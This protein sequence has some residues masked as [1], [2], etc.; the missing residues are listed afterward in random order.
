MLGWAGEA[1]AQPDDIIIE[2]VGPKEVREDVGATVDITV[3]VTAL[4]AN[5]A[6]VDPGRDT[7]V[8]LNITSQPENQLNIRFTV[9]EIPT[10]KIA[11]D[12]DPLS[13]TGT[14]KFT[15]IPTV[16]RRMRST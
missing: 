12:A 8:I 5:D 9:D 15:P 11:K 4:D 1:E 14:F 6:P 10:L 13:A 2:V 3:K 16:T 7:Y